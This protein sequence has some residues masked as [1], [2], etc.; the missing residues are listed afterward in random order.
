MNNGVNAGYYTIEASKDGYSTYHHNETIKPG[1][2]EFT[3]NMSPVIQVQG[4]Y[5]I[6]LTWGETP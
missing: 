4:E 3:I 6:V 5:R 1:E 2:N